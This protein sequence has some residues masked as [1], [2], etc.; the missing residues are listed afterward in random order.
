MKDRIDHQIDST[1]IVDK[2][3]KDVSEKTMTDLAAMH[4]ELTSLPELPEVEWTRLRALEFQEVLRQRT[5]YLERI[6][7]LGC[8]LCENFEDHVR[9]Y[10]TDKMR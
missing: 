1:A 6:A 3:S 2:K 10:F 8:Q 9:P 4:E 7:K 5:S